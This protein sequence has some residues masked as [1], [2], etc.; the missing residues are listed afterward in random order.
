MSDWT[1]FYSTQFEAYKDKETGN[2][3]YLAGQND[4]YEVVWFP[5]HGQRAILKT[6]NYETVRNKMMEVMYGKKRRDK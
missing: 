1:N 2:I 3:V 4:E 5:I 6:G